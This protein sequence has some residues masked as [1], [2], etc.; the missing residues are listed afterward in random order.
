M[1]QKSK[2]SN[3]V[4]KSLLILAAVSAG[5]ILFV[6]IGAE[7]IKRTERAE[8]LKWASESVEFSQSGYYLTAWQKAQCKAHNIEIN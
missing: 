5:V 4:F 7:G 8:C 1:A 3:D 6:Y 2:A